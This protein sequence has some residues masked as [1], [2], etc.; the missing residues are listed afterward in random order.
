MPVNRPGSSN[1]PDLAVGIFLMALLVVVFGGLYWMGQE[2]EAEDAYSQNLLETKLQFEEGAAYPVKVIGIRNVQTGISGDFF[3]A[4]GSISGLDEIPV[5]VVSV[6]I[7][8]SDYIRYVALSDVA[9]RQVEDKQDA[10]MTID[11]REGFSGLS[12]YDDDTLNDVFERYFNG[13][14]IELSPE[15]YAQLIEDM[16]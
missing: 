1:G 12:V 13:A 9:F 15:D 7:G 10:T 16:P 2:A 5:V 8:E 14:V 4:S 3:L 11:L 6:T